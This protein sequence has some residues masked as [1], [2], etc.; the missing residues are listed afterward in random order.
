M[1]NGDGFIDLDNNIRY[2]QKDYKAKSG[3]KVFEIEIN[4]N[5]SLEG[6]LKSECQNFEV[7]PFLIKKLSETKQKH[8]GVIDR[9]IEDIKANGLYSW[10]PKKSIDLNLNQMHNDE[11]INQNKGIKI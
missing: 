9:W 10:R 1:S 8:Q 11:D 4:S 6:V 7:D 5:H 2:L 3:W